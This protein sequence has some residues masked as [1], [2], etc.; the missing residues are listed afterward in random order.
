M[1]ATKPKIDDAQYEAG[2]AAFFKGMTLRDLVERTQA[3]SDTSEGFAK[4]SDDED[5]KMSFALGFGDGLLMLL[6]G[7][8]Q[9]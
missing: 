9:S 2:K 5:R 3:P 7:Q 1:P 4:F 6:R 8:L